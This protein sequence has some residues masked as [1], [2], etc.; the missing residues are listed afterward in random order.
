MVAKHLRKSHDSAIR[1]STTRKRDSFFPLLSLPT[2]FV[3]ATATY[4]S[5]TVLF[6]SSLR[7]AL[8]A[9]LPPITRKLAIGAFAAA[10]VQVFLGISTLLYL[11]PVPIAAAHQAG[12]VALLTCM[13]ALVTSLRR[14]HP[15]CRLWR[16][17]YHR[18]TGFD[19]NL[20]FSTV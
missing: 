5:T 19:N 18:S 6:L 12:S 7:P 13:I 3:Q 1:S 16:E 10:N 9:A 17:V 15:V 14:P 2:R 11:V 20:H 8:R 4:L